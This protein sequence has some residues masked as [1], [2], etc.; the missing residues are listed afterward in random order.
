MGV[1]GSVAAF[2]EE[3]TSPNVHRNVSFRKLLS[4]AKTAAVTTSL[5]P[6]PAGLVLGTATFP[7]WGTLQERPRG[8]DLS[9]VS[10]AH[11]TSV[12]MGGFWSSM[13]VRITCQVLKHPH[14]VPQ[15][16]IL[17]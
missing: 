5:I 14:L 8:A 9:A 10:Q 6:L 17:V 13:H 11:K 16:A 12:L 2:E 1:S 7:A 15:P 3:L 4:L